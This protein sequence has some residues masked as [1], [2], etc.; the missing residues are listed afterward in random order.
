MKTIADKNQM[1]VAEHAVRNVI[2]KM[3]RERIGSFKFA[4][5]NQLRGMYW[6]LCDLGY[7]DEEFMQDAWKAMSDDMNSMR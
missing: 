1:K 6:L 3:Q 5:L 7:R 2:K 4:Y